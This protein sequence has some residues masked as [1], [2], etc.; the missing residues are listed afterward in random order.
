ME[1]ITCSKRAGGIYLAI[2][3]EFLRGGPT[4]DCYSMIRCILLLRPL[5]NAPLAKTDTW[6][7]RGLDRSVATTHLQLHQFMLKN[8]LSL[9]DCKRL[10]ERYTMMLTS[11]ILTKNSLCSDDL[12]FACGDRRQSQQKF[13]P[14][15]LDSH[16][17]IQWQMTLKQLAKEICDSYLTI[18]RFLL[19][20]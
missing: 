12:N 18:D 11:P 3:S 14:S 15:P 5:T 10:F 6:P 8:L 13:Y 9:D 1:D 17:T 7:G 19:L 16:Q 4:R 2:S 20:S